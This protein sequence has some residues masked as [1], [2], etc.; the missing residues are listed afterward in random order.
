MRNVLRICAIVALL[1][2]T[3][4][5][6]TAFGQASPA[7]P[8]A[9]AAAVQGVIQQVAPSTTAPAGSGPIQSTSPGSLVPGTNNLQ[10]QVNGVYPPPTGP[11]T[12]SP[13]TTQGV[14][15][16]TPGTTMTTPG[17]AGTGV[18]AVNQGSVNPMGTTMTPGYY[19][20]GVPG[21]AYGMR[22]AN[23]YNS[24]YVTPGYA[25]PGQNYYYTNPAQTYV[26]R[27]RRGLFGGLF[28]RRRQA[29]ATVANGYTYGT[30]PGTYY[31]ST[32]P[33]TYTYAPAPY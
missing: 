13:N 23:T 11:V 25:N 22:P 20:S 4:S 15:G 9:G 29:Y 32:A 19:Y 26:T 27:P 1:G 7:K 2:S 28:G 12:T 5:L 17:Y 31:Y 3:A 24:M 30:A 18:P 10:Q 16:N 21:G 6:E 14:V 33:G 8:S